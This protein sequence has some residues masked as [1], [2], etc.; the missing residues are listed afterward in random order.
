MEQNKVRS[1]IFF[2]VANV[3]TGVVLTLLIF[4]N[5]SKSASEGYWRV[6]QLS[7]PHLRL[8]VLAHSDQPEDQE[9]KREIVATVQQIFAREDFLL[10]GLAE[11]RPPNLFR[12]DILRL[13]KKLSDLMGP[14]ASQDKKISLHFME[15][16][17]PLR[18][19]NTTIYPPGEYHALQVVVGEGEGENWWCLLFP[20]LC[21]P[22]AGGEKGDNGGEAN[23][24]QAVERPAGEAKEGTSGEGATK[25]ERN[26]DLFLK[27]VWRFL[28]R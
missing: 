13:E 1:K 6:A 26:W 10:D 14:T 25:K 16:T 18:V 11:E 21:L 27:R 19:Y 2:I 22:L 8:H 7:Q 24:E 9:Y 23:G 3:L 20:P 28:Q 15:K 5:L 12:E 4:T 17:F